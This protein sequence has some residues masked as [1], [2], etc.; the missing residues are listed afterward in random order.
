M[1]GAADVAGEMALGRVVDQYMRET[2]YQPTVF[3]GSSMGAAEFG[4]LKLKAKSQT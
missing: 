3:S 4:C 1:M 2:S